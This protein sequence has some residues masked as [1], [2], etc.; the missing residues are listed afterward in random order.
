MAA[1]RI[2]LNFFAMPFGLAGLAGSWQLASEYGRAP[3]AVATVLFAVAALVWAAVLA[4]YL[5][6]LG[7]DRAGF[8]RDLLDPVAAPF[9]SLAVITPML[10]AVE[11]LYPHAPQAGRVLFDVF[12]ALTVLLGAWFTGQWMY[13]GG[14]DLDRFHPGYFLPTV[15]GGLLASAGAA[16]VGQRRLAEAMF[17][18]GIVCWLVLGSIILGRLFFR[19]R[20]PAPLMPTLAI[21]VAPAAVASLAYFALHGDHIDATAAFLGGYGLLMVL[22]Q[23]RLLP[24]YL[25][26]PFMP[27]TWAFTFSWAAV[28]TAALHWLNA[29]RPSGY[30]VWQY[31]VLAAVSALVG[32]IALRTLVALR[33]HQLLPGQPQPQPSAGPSSAA[34]PVS[35]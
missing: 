7:R 28:A 33:R 2:P 5:R 27:S 11:G 35:R 23:L 10:L 13:G 20:L 26:L 25:A 19:P 4:A 12:L 6:Y 15:A 3:Q 22:A 16:A 30:Q 31:L 34:E 1:Q 14:L 29:L 9:A 21:E 17:G 24:G 32:A 8:G 18:L